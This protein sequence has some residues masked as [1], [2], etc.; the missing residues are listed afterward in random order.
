MKIKDLRNNFVAS[1]SELY[2]IEEARS[3]FYLLSENKLGLRRIDIAL[4][5][6]KV[7]SKDVLRYFEEAQSRLL[8]QE[9]IQYILGNTEFYGLMFQVNKNVLIPRQETEELVDWI[10]KDCQ[11]RISNKSLKILDIGTGSGCIAISLAKTIEGAEV[12]AIDVSEKAIEVAKQN[13]Q[14]NNVDIQFVHQDILKVDTLNENFDIIVSNPPYVRELEKKEIKPNV[15]DNEPDIALFVSDQDPLVFYRKITE[16]AKE[17]LAVDGMLYFEIN[18][19][20]GFETKKMIQEFGYTSVD[21]RKDIYD[22]DRMI[23]AGYM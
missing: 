23:K 2:G 8:N 6:E 19:Y 1:L 14:S 12:F 5:L 15:L 4:V 10:I 18:Q 21:L 11:N 3:F 13:A 17:S 20:L 22:N 16:L 7:M 9:P